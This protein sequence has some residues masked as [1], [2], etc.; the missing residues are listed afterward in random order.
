MDEDLGMD[1]THPLVAATLATLGLS[2]A[3]RP[4]AVLPRDRSQA[5]PATVSASQ[6]WRLVLASAHVIATVGYAGATIEAITAE[7]GVS[8]KTFYK[9]FS[10]KEEAFLACYEGLDSVL[11]YVVGLA[12]AAPD[13]DRAVDLVIEGYLSALAAA[14]DLTRLFLIEALTASPRIR[15]KRAENLERFATILQDA[16]ADLRHGDHTIGHLADGEA[17]ALLGGLNE[18]CVRHITRHPVDSLP[19]IRDDVANFTRRTLRPLR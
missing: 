3:D 11:S 12:G 14:P 8:K 18:L 1:A 5:D 9:F 6:R 17:I 19:A 7:A 15:L 13:L 4:A 10:G 2:E 16:L